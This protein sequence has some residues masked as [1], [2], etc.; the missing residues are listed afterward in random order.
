MGIY[1]PNAWIDEGEAWLCLYTGTHLAH[2]QSRD[3]TNR[4][5]PIMGVRWSKNRFV[6]LH[7]GRVPGGFLSEPF[8][9]QGET[10]TVDADVRGWLRAELCDVFGRKQEGHHLMDA[11]PVVGD[12]SAHVLRWQDTD[13]ARYQHDVVR[14]R[15]EFVE[16]EI[17]GI[18][19]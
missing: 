10:I 11:V 9:P 19:F 12:D 5:R 7:A 18:G 15:F 3:Q 8:Y 2:N 14:L 4:P 13:S 16:G 1:A 17:Y 6:G